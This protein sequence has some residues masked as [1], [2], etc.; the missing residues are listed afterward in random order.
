MPSELTLAYRALI[1]PTSK[2]SAVFDQPPLLVNCVSATIGGFRGAKNQSAVTTY[3]ACQ[4]LPTLRPYHV[5]TI[6]KAEQ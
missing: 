5:P 1:W 6:R 3:D 4:M 2:D